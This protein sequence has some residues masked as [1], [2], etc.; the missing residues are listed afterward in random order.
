MCDKS[1]GNPQLSVDDGAMSE[2]KASMSLPH[3]EFIWPLSSILYFAT[4]RLRL[5]TIYVDNG[6]VYL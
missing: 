6:K 1:L 5:L 2:V 3:S 4:A